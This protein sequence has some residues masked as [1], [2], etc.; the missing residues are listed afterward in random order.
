M[1]VRRGENILSRGLFLFAR[2]VLSL[3]HYEEV[4]TES[5]QSLS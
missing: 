2:H 4:G 1:G 5:I 3:D